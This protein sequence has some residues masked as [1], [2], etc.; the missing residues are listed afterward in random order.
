[1]IKPVNRCILKVA[2]LVGGAM[3]AG[4]AAL[5]PDGQWRGTPEA[6]LRSCQ[7][8][9]GSAVMSVREQVAAATGAPA[10]PASV[11]A[12]QCP[13]SGT[14][15]ATYAPNAPAPRTLSPQEVV[16]LGGD[17]ERAY[18]EGRYAESV[19]LLDAFL[20]A[21]P[22]HAAAW[23]RKG[24]ALHRLERAGEA[25]TAYRRALA[26]TLYP[27]ASA[28]WPDTG[29]V[30]L[31]SKAS[32]DLAGLVIEQAKLALDALGAADSNSV[33]AAH[34]ARIEAAMRAVIGMGV[35]VAPPGAAAPLPAQTAR[36]ASLVVS[37]AVSTPG[38]GA[39]APASDPPTAR[40]AVEVIRGLVAR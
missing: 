26:L 36:P 8:M 35:E 15:S 27:A 39:A 33:A 38:P 37:A 32:A 25:A 13:A 24:N 12:S 34:R 28:Q 21:Q 30:D 23:L 5:D 9:F 10:A 40:P 16:Q 4:C 7:A 1:V 2:V 31:R 11:A 6:R 22:S 17:A 20:A 18:V 14:S 19:E 29:V 3:L